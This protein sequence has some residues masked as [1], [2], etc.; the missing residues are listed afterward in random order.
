MFMLIVQKGAVV[1]K[2]VT[3]PAYKAAVKPRRHR[4]RSQWMHAM[5]GKARSWDAEHYA[6]KHNGEWHLCAATNHDVPLKT[7]PGDARAAA[8]MTLIRW[9]MR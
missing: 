1:A 7:L 2:Q 4:T 3:A 6:F 9:A 8:E 5:N